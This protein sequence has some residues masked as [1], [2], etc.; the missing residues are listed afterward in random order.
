MISIFVCEDN[1]QYLKTISN[2]IKNYL[3]IEKLDAEL[4]LSTADP[5]EITQ[6]IKTNN[7]IKGLYFLDVELEGGY[8][9]VEV[10]QTIRK[11]DPR[12]FIVFVT[13]YPQYLA[14]TFEYQV[15]ALDYIQKSDDGSTQQ[16]IGT[17]IQNAYQKHVA[18]SNSA[19]YVFK[20]QNE[21]KISCEYSEIL[22]FETDPLS[23]RKLILHTKSK[24]YT[25]YGSLDKLFEKL[26]KS[27]FFKCHKAFVV[28]LDNITEQCKDDLLQGHGI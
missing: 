22:F 28:N 27:S 1:Q 14:L 13:A 24:Q 15:E 23:P 19:S 3:S 9:G 18:R 16:R 7:K 17:C 26:P 4:V 20:A 2:A 11:Y 25:F 8:N 6:R 5:A 12:G 21:C 10:A